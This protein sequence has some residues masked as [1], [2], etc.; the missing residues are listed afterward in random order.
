MDYLPTAINKEAQAVNNFTYTI[1]V[2]IE[3]ERKLKYFT[4]FIGTDMFWICFWF[5]THHQIFRNRNSVLSLEDQFQLVLL[6]LRLGIT[7]QFTAHLFHISTSTIGKYFRDWI[8]KMYKRF[9]A[10]NIWP[11]REKIINTKPE[12]VALK[13]P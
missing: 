10:L 3:D 7:E 2:I 12:S 5:I 13:W 8:D 1:R 9:K 11:T 4:G 6:R